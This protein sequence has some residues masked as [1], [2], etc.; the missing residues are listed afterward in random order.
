M[1]APSASL[2]L[3]NGVPPLLLVKQ[4]DSDVRGPSRLVEGYAVGPTAS[5]ADACEVQPIIDDGQFDWLGNFHNVTI[6]H[7]ATPSVGEDSNLPA[8]QSVNAGGWA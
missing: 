8:L 6:R 5:P 4:P 3:P 7:F 2:D 1:T